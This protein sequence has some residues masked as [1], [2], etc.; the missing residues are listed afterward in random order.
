M[1]ELTLLGGGGVV[2]TT[3][4]NLK[5]IKI[6]IFLTPV[7]CFLRAA[8][9]AHVYDSTPVAGEGCVCAHADAVCTL[10]GACGR[11]QGSLV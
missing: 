11:S 6:S 9:C 3:S 8:V 4:F 2:P 1:A 10:M 7:P 5:E